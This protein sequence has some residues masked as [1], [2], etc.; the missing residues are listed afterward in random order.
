ML[1][2]V[3]LIASDENLSQIN[4]EEIYCLMMKHLKVSYQGFNNQFIGRA[5]DAA[6]P[7]RQMEAEL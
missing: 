6:S 5:K 4:L 1:F 2:S 7:R 3:L